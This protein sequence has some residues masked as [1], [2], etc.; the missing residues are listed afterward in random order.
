MFSVMVLS[1]K[2][3]VQRPL[4]VLCLTRLGELLMVSGGRWSLHLLSLLRHLLS[5][6]LVECFVSEEFPKPNFSR[7]AKLLSLSSQQ[8]YNRHR[9]L[10]LLS[11]ISGTCP[12]IC[13]LI[14][15][16]FPRAL[17]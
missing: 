5:K 17:I 6:R 12:P 1:I 4:A 11:P 9:K 14:G 13:L 3:I 10:M 8:T 15:V 16:L 2:I 7:T